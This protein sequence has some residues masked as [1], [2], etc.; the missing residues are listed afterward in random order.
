MA[1]RR[2]RSR[3]LP[4]RL[5]ADA[6]RNSEAERHR[7]AGLARRRCSPASPTHRSPSSA[8]SYRGTGRP[9]FNGTSGQPRSRRIP[10]RHGVCVIPRNA[11]LPPHTPYAEKAIRRMPAPDYHP[12]AFVEPKGAAPPRANSAPAPRRV[13]NA[14]FLPCARRKRLAKT[15][16]G[17]APTR[18]TKTRKTKDQKRNITA[19]VAAGVPMNLAHASTA[20]PPPVFHLGRSGTLTAWRTVRRSTADRPLMRVRCRTG[21]QSV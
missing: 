7:S 8:N 4:L 2:F 19:V 17:L 15:Q 13:G 12:C 1:R 3:S 6:D 11:P 14:S 16:N 10:R 5:H 9:K 21:H 20:G 18:A